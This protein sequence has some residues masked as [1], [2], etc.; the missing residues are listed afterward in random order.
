MSQFVKN[1]SPRGSS[2]KWKRFLNAAHFLTAAL[3]CMYKQYTGSYES[4][5]K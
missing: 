5:I 3:F 1:E 4:E 2:E